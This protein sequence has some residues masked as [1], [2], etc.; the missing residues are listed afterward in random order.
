[1]TPDYYSPAESQTIVHYNHHYVKEKKPALH[2][3]LQKEHVYTT[4]TMPMMMENITPPSFQE[5]NFKTT[6]SNFKIMPSIELTPTTQ[7]TPAQSVSPIYA[8]TMK[9]TFFLPTI[10]TTTNAPLT[11]ST[12]IIAATSILSQFS[13]PSSSSSDPMGLII[14]GH[15]NVKTYGQ[16]SNE[17]K[18]HDPIIVQIL[19]SDNPVT[20]HVVLEDDRGNP[21]VVKHL[22]LRKNETRVTPSAPKDSES[23]MQSL[24]SLLDTSFGGLMLDKKPIRNYEKENKIREVF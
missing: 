21:T 2:S 19:A 12:P 16:N 17:P 3:L 1:M 7:R 18:K 10:P 11:Q 13:Q 15:S 23:T 4:M 20:K 14:E 24:I 8:P 22:H 9:T 5:H 6:T